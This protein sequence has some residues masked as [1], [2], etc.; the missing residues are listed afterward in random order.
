MNK[1]FAG[2]VFFLAIF[3]FQGQANDQIENI[4]QYHQNS[5]WQKDTAIELFDEIAKKEKFKG[6]ETLVDVCSGDG[7]ITAIIAQH[8]PD[9]KVIGVDISENM[10][11]FSNK[12]YGKSSPNL[13]FQKMDATQLSFPGNVD[14]ITS[15]TCMHTIANHKAV[16]A[17]MHQSLKPQGKVLML[18]PVVHGFGN[19]LEKVTSN[20]KWRPYFKTFKPNW[21]FVTAA[22]YVKLLQTTGLKPERVNVFTKSETYPSKEVFADAI[23]H[24][25]PHLKVLPEQLRAEFLSDLLA[26]YLQQVPLNANGEL[27][28][29]VDNIVVEAQK[30]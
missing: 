4:A 3:P 18:F 23:S 27:H 16:L 29:Y 6:T 7:K 14:V 20:E 8:F 1:N 25:L 13:S 24:W 22:E 28:Y 9:G 30:A 11:E 5:K 26:S 12:H 2:L 17:S 15:F 10:L 19:A 21:H